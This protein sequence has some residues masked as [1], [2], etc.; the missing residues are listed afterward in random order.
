VNNPG[1]G[2]RLNQVQPGSRDDKSAKQLTEATPKQRY[3]DSCAN[4][5]RKSASG[6]EFF[7]IVPAEEQDAI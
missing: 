6:R 2:E 7:E 5:I 3:N 1:R 4:A